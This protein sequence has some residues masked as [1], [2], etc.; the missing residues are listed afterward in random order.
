MEK[1]GL[2]KRYYEERVRIDDM[3][4]FENLDLSFVN[5]LKGTSGYAVFSAA[6]SLGDAIVLL[7]QATKKAI[8]M[9]CSPN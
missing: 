3:P 8:D 4:A 1:I 9:I 5:H 7:R 6:I 2:L